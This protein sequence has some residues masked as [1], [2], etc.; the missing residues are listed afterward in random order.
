MST[1]FKLDLNEREITD[2]LKKA[3]RSANEKFGEESQREITSPKWDY[4]KPGSDIVD[5]G[6][7]RDSYTTSTTPDGLE[8]SHS[9]TAR[10]AMANH[11]GAEYRDGRKRPP[12]RWTK[13][14][15]DNFENNFDAVAKTLL[16]AV[17]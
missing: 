8:T 16:E 13:E 10:H 2:A 6:Q 14:P 12:R 3:F 15:H 17:K 11:E 5:L 4:P 1:T 7:L 9:W